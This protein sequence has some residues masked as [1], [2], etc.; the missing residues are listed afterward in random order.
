MRRGPSVT[1]ALVLAL[2]LGLTMTQPALGGVGTTRQVSLTTRGTDPVRDSTIGANSISADGRY[3][4]FSSDDGN[5]VK[6][7]RNK[8]QDVFVRGGTTVRASVDTGGG[9]P[10]GYSSDPSISADGRYVAFQ[11]AASDLVAADGNGFLDVFV[12]D[13]VFGTTVRASVDTAGEDPDADSFV[14]SNSADGR[15]VAF[16]SK[17]SDLV[18]GDG[19][20]SLDVFV[21][22]LVAGTTVRASVDTGGGDPDDVSYIPS[23]SADGR[24]VAFWSHASDLVAGDGNGYP[25]VFVRDLVAG[26][27]VR[28]SVDTGGGDP[29]GDSHTPSIS[30]DGRY[31]A[32]YSVASDLGKG[33]GN[34]FFDVF[35]RDLA[36]ET[37]VRASVD[38]GGGDPN[39]GSF[40]P[41]INADGRSV[42]F[43]SFA[44]DLVQDDGNGTYDV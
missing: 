31:V 8:Y 25:N 39:E 30:T 34:G 24:Y 14:W 3:V 17:A 11:S 5:L 29:N 15:Y 20:S 44:S 42:A 12:R 26:T 19:N 32:F 10:N 33:D 7:D 18:A 16:M 9:D 38:A 28:A 21:G 22:D 2:G 4:A 35:V 41:S 1:L 40:Q 27:T 37:T 6:G 36:T 43:Q 23:I 13:L